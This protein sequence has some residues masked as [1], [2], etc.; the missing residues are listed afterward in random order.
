MEV[1]RYIFQ[2]P[3]SN[4]VQ[5]GQ[6]DTS[7]NSTSKESSSSNNPVENITSLEAKT[8]QESPKTTQ[9]S[10]KVDSNTLL[11]MYV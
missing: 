1:T 11:D 2:S 9:E 6:P 7:S 3:Y 4:Q 5:I 10:Q 8:P